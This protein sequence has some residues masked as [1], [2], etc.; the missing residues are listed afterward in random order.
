MRLGNMSNKYAAR[1]NI[2]LVDN[3]PRLL[4]LL[5]QLLVA[6]GYRVTTAANR[7]EAL[8]RLEAERFHIAVVDARLDDSDPYNDDGFRLVRDLRQ[9]DPSTGVILLTAN[10]DLGI[11]REALYGVSGEL[12]PTFEI[13]RTTASAYLEKK[14]RALRNLPACI[15]KI[16]EDVVQVNWSLQIVDL[17][18]FLMLMP[19]RMRFH[20]APDIPELQIEL[21]E[22]MRKL[23]AEWQR[24]DIHTIAEQNQGY[25][26]AFVFQVT[27]YNEDGEGQL[28]IAKVGEIGVI[29][30]EVQRHREFIAP[31]NPGGRN[32]SRIDS[33]R[34][35]RN[36][37]GMIYHFDG[38][39][40]SNIRDFAQFF[41]GTKDRA[42][43]TDVIGNLFV[44]TL[45]F[46]H[47]MPRVT[48]QNVD[49]REVYMQVLRIDEQELNTKFDELIVIA[50][51]L[52]RSSLAEKFG[53]ANTVPL[54]NPLDYA[55]NGSFTASYV[56]T[57]I[58]GD[59]H[60]H[61]VLI[62]FCNDTWLIDFHNTGKGPL[63]QDFI[64]F[65]A[66]LL[67]EN[68]ECP[69]GK[70]LFEWSRALFSKPGE[71]FPMMPDRLTSAPELIKTHYAIMT[72]RRLA[73]RECPGEGVERAYLIGMFFTTLR[74]MS[75]KFLTPPKRF[76]ALTVAALIAEN[77][78]ALETGR[79][80]ERLEW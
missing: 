47:S 52:D 10:A 20:V 40:G 78:L 1:C 55:A 26:K 21:E 19:R 24:I 3:S 56:E 62:D 72:V 30:R 59:L 60:A 61:N 68:N 2:L 32:P 75:V 38:L 11:A 45:A 37:G 29:E 80:A 57:V 70:Q 14:P 49:L 58:H 9:L 13:S 46:E 28:L 41:H 7:S 31:R 36:L 50:K 18:Q 73:L 25:N 74:L 63:L 48:H 69:P 15:Q 42:L 5:E 44:D 53:L 64:S 22:L 39:P 77:L 54:L 66:S 23:F 33:V 8:K 35:T 76:H 6:E 17:E 65:E 16:L 12:L 34:R 43:I 27:P 67:V 51:S 71:L 79:T 4:P